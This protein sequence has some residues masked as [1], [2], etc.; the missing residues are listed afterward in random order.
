M[1]LLHHKRS[2]WMNGQSPQHPCPHPIDSSSSPPWGL[3]LRATVASQLAHVSL[4]LAAALPQVSNEIIA[5]CRATIDLDEGMAGGD[6]GQVMGALQQ[7]CQVRC[8]GTL[9]A[10]GWGGKAGEARARPTSR[11]PAW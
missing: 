1:S 5:C 10:L 7:A 11:L 4:R 8:A 2:F 6:V 3:V 9:D